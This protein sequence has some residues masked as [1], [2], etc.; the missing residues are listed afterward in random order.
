MRQSEITEFLV[1]NVEINLDAVDEVRSHRSIKILSNF[2]SS[3]AR[4]MNFEISCAMIRECWD[5]IQNPIAVDEVL[6]HLSIGISNVFKNR[7]IDLWDPM[8]FYCQFG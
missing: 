5:K 8:F 7:R 4:L 3:A 1:T 2:N 6:L